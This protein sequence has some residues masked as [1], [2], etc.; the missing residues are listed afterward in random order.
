MMRSA[1]VAAALGAVVGSGLAGGVIV[2]R[3]QS[4]TTAVSIDNFTFTPQKLTVK[5][6][7][8]ITWT[9]KDDIPHGIA[10]TANAF[11]KS[12]ALDTDDS[13]SFTFTT[14][15]T[16]QYFLLHPSAHDRH[17]RGRSSNGQQ[18]HTV[19]LARVQQQPSSWTAGRET[20]AGDAHDEDDRARRFRDAAL[21]YLDDAYTLA[22]YLMRNA[23]DAE[24]AVQECYLR[25]LRHFDSYRG[26]AMKPWL[27]TILRNV[28]NAEFARRGRQESPSE[29]AEEESTAEVLPM[30]QEPQTSP[31]VVLLRQQDSD[32]I[33]KLVAGLPQPFREAIVL[34]EMNDLSYHE[35]AEV[36]G[37]PVGTVMSRLARARTM[38]RSAWNVAEGSTP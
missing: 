13:Y 38:L 29:F 19:M 25:A 34:R 28:C 26:P 37:V 6:G 4:A 21:P 33:R 8:T 18:R 12:K 23:A 11:T 17:D 16:Y 27:L 30:W 14:P 3:A 32:T 35:I 36:A 15:G 24:D 1:I 7:T 22:R 10:A 2:A 9:N 31:E 20:M 5:A